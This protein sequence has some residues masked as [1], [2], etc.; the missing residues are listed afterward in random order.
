MWAFILSLLGIAGV[1]ILLRMRKKL[2][3]GH[4]RSKIFAHI[5][6]F[7]T[8]FFLSCLF[9]TAC[10]LMLGK[11]SENILSDYA[12]VALLIVVVITWAIQ[13]AGSAIEDVLSAPIPAPSALAP[14]GTAQ[15]TNQ[16]PPSAAPEQKQLTQ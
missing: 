8:W 15:I 7:F 13:R 1:L 5:M 12:G 3:I 9:V 10:L 16:S 2:Y 11:N 4:P 14:P 6:T